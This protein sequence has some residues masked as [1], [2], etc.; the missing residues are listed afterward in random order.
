MVVSDLSTLAIEL[1]SVIPSSA[2]AERCWS[3][4]GYIH[5]KSRNRLTNDRAEKL[6]Y[7]YVNS[8][9]FDR[10]DLTPAYFPKKELTKGM[11]QDTAT[12]CELA[13]DEAEAVYASEEN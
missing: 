10:I 2:A 4:V 8:R 7:V 12:F 1:L 9:L 3:S 13:E 5:S 6:V 11:D